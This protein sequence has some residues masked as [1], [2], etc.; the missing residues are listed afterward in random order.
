MISYFQVLFMWLALG[1]NLQINAVF[2]LILSSKK[3]NGR[4]NSSLVQHTLLRCCYL[5]HLSEN[6]FLNEKFRPGVLSLLQHSGEASG[7]A[8]VPFRSKSGLVSV[9]KKKILG[10]VENGFRSSYVGS[11]PVG[12]ITGRVKECVGQEEV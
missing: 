11:L 10:E 8:H 2:S 5:W 4:D 1:R 6:I 3:I 9:C 12:Y 7:G